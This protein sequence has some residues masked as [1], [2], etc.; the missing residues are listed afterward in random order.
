MK[1]LNK[2]LILAFTINWGIAIGQI[3][4]SNKK[5]KED[6]AHQIFAHVEIMPEFPGGENAFKEYI[7]NCPYPETAINNNIQGKVYIYFI[8]DTTGKP[9]DIKVVRG[10]E[11]TIDEAVLNYFMGMP[12][13]RPGKQNKRLVP[14]QFTVPVA[15]EK[16]A[17]QKK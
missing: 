7:K 5:H 10:L 3:T 14:V 11:K 9:I 2:F 12:T 8:I 13:W 6:S 17:I 15:F 16:K 1:S 4:D